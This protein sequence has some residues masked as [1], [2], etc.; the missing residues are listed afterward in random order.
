M[1]CLEA[2]RGR[3]PAQ[4]RHG[5]AIGIDGQSASP[6][7]ARQVPGRGGTGAKPAGFFNNKNI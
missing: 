7:T 1:A 3:R 2:I 4:R 6:N 5:G